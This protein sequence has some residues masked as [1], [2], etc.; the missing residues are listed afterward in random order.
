[1]TQE[2]KR[3]ARVF[4][5]K[6]SAS[7]SDSLAFFTAPSMF[8]KESEITEVHVSVTFSYDV[9]LA[10]C[11]ARAW[12][13]IAPVKIG[14]VA[15]GDPG[16]QFE[17]GVYLKPG[18]T[19]TSRGCPNK[20]WFC[21]VHAREGNIREYEIR[22]GWNLLDSNILACSDKHI[23]KT[24][25]MLAR[26]SHRAEF[27]GGLEAARLKYWHVDLLWSL[28]PAQMFFAY[29]TSDDREP[30]YEAGKLLRHANFTR[31]HMRCYVLIGWPA[32]TFDAAEQR[33]LD[34]WE[35]GFMPMAMLY[36]G[37]SDAE[38]DKEWQKFQRL[39]ARPALTKAIMRDAFHNSLRG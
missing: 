29:D 35:F 2:S 27:T 26:Q 11:L 16:G 8:T 20:C 21:D 22:D 30:L 3:V 14:G 4:P 39:W 13:S 24:F 28:C 36:R 12:E 31:S 17:P 25:K 23:T 15:F 32:D 34:T 1:M 5:R 9:E 6:T 19:I 33:L 10:E 37:K 7:P 18:Y 38:P